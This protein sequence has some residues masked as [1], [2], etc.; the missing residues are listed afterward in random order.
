MI[1]A[2]LSIGDELVL[3]QKRDEHGPWLADRLAAH[4]APPIEQRVIGD[5]RGGIAAA[6]TDLARRAD[7]LVIT[8][9]L[10]PTADDLTRQALAEALGEDLVI[11]DEAM[12][13]LH[14]LFQRHDRPMPVGNE[15]QAMRP[16]NMRCLENPLGTAPGLTGRLGRCVIFALPGPPNEMHRMYHRVVEPAVIETT[17]AEAVI[18]T[19]VNAFGFGES[20]AAQKLGDL[21]DRTRDV[22]VGTTVSGSVLTARI[23]A[24][25]PPDRQQAAVNQVADEV[26][27]C[28]GP[29]VFGR[30][31]VDLSQAVGTMLLE[32]SCRVAT[33]ESCTGGWLGKRLVD[34]A[35]SSAYYV[36]GWVCYTNALKVAQ[37]GVSEELLNRCGAVSVP[38]AAAMAEGAR[39]RCDADLAL[40]ITGIAGPDGGGPD[41]PVGTVFIGLAGA[42]APTQVRH[43]QFVGDRA[44][45]RDRSVKSALQMLRFHLLDA[46]VRLLWQRGDAEAVP[47]S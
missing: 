5:D 17:G 24:T 20:D 39:A 7:L 1:S 9:G 33:A 11:D 21:M 12:R 8:G 22:L 36:G 42:Q 34:V 30:D 23:R 45:I 47:S 46:Q 14:E 29:Y 31:Q 38:V 32:H 2:L 35:G 3:G 44:A 43:F 28:W 18:R 6:V 25:G 40:S 16:Q 13:H 37:L 10:G 41:K 19:Q 15:V 26:E 4:G 27:R